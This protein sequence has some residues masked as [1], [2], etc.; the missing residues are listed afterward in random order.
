MVEFSSM[1]FMF[2][3]GSK[4]HIFATDMTE[5]GLFVRGDSVYNLLKIIRNVIQNNCQ[6]VTADK[7]V[8]RQAMIIRWLRL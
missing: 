3:S 7:D 1:G 5:S 2:S 6:M 8:S 4:D